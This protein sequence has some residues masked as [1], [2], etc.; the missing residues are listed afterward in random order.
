M[1]NNF[2]GR[3]K[4]SSGTEIRVLNLQKPNDVLVCH[5]DNTRKEMTAKALTPPYVRKS[6]L[7]VVRDDHP[8]AGGKIRES[9]HIS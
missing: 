9:H 2:L 1:E 3:K 4:Q 8:R 6:H 5:R 7:P